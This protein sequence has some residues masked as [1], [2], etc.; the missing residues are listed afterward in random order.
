MFGRKKKREPG[1]G[2]IEKT[3]SYMLAVPREIESVQ[4]PMEILARLK[5]GSLFE[6]EQAELQD[7][8]IKVL[9][10]L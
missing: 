10:Q 9:I 6:T 4:N 2:V 7:G 5:T 1:S 3:V 8:H